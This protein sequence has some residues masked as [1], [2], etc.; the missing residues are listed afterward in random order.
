MRIILLGPPGAGKGTQAEFISEQFKIPK[1]A[2]GDMLR[3][4]IEAH[5]P[6]GQEVKSLMAAGQFVPESIVIDLV[7][8]RIAK[9]DAQT[10][11]LLDGFPRTLYQ[12]ET[13]KALG[14]PIDAIVHFKVPDENIIARLSGRRIHPHSGRV[15]H[16]LYNP[17]REMG[18]DDVTGEP[19]V[20]REDDNENAIR[21][22]LK[23]YH[24]ETEPLISW[25]KKQ[26]YPFIEIKGEDS[27]VAVNQKILE[28][29]KGLNKEESKQV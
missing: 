25:Y 16:V 8:N 23:I 9:S 11:F 2:T 24:Q 19:L 26:N 1:I 7:K 6:I 12:A 5:T 4:E 14:I 28:A 21:K 18:K 10:G 29:L 3:A 17:P 15:Y 20:Q 27:V 22:R 13:L